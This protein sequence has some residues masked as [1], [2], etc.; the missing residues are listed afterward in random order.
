MFIQVG[1][2]LTVIIVGL[3]SCK[4]GEV[5]GFGNEKSFTMDMP[6]ELN[7][8][9]LR[10]GAEVVKW[11]QQLWVVCFGKLGIKIWE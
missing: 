11:K 9:R 3:K 4:V 10:A 5:T 7:C 2:L 1:T 6:Q 8:I